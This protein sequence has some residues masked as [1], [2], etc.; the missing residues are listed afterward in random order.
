MRAVLVK[1]GIVENIIVWDETCQEIPGYTHI[2][3]EDDYTVSIG[4]HYNEETQELFDP[5]PVDPDAWME[6]IPYNQLRK[7]KYPDIGEY[8]DGIVKGDQEQIDKYIQDCLEIKARFP[9]PE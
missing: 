1:N 7:L 4:W 3:V 6:G 5:N 8:L 2:E 9:K